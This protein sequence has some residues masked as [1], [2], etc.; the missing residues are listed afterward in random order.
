MPWTVRFALAAH[1]AG[2]TLPPHLLM[3]VQMVRNGHGCTSQPT[4]Y[5]GATQ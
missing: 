2:W 4:R 3:C 5:T 1:D